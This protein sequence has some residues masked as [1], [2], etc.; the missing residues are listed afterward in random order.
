MCQAQNFSTLSTFL[1]RRWQAAAVSRNFFLSL[2]LSVQ[3][4]ACSEKADS[5]INPEKT[6]TLNC[7]GESGTS[8]DEGSR[9]EFSFKVT[10]DG[11][12]Q[13]YLFTVLSPL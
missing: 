11:E 13:R 12:H 4:I 8:N 6:F 5:R 9:G 10:V 3:V 2:C 1:V 7:K